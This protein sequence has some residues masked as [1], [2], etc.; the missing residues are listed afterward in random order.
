MNLTFYY[1]VR[2][3]LIYKSKCEYKGLS[4]E[5]TRAKYEKIKELLLKRYPNEPSDNT[6]EQ[7]PRVSHFFQQ[8]SSF[9][10]I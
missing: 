9:P 7:F 3:A 4:W 5:G 6:N 8:Q 10:V 1:G 2:C